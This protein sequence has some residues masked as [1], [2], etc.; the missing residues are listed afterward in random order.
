VSSAA[1]L[2]IG[3]VTFLFTDIEGSTQLL[4]RL[5]GERYGQ[6]LAD[7]Q[8]LLRESFAEHGGHEID[9]QGDSFF[10]A[11]RRAK[12]A[13]SAAIACQR[14]LAEHAWPD[15]AEL[16]VRMGIHTGEPAVGGTRYVGLGVHRAARICAA[17]HGGQ[18][19]VSQTARE[20][21][22]DDPISDVTARDLGEHHLKDLDEPE[23]LYQLV[24][25]GL[26]EDFPPLKTAASAPFEGREGELAEAAAEE[27]ARG[28]GRPTRR[29]L[30]LATF[31][32]AVVAAA[33]AVLVSR[34]GGTTAGASI[35]PNAV[36]VIDAESGEVA[37]EI[38]VG[39]APVDVA[40][41]PDAVWVTNANDNTVS[42]IDPSTNDVRQTIRVGGGPASVAVGGGAVWVANGLDGTVS[43]I[44]PTTNQ[45]VQ[46]ITVGNGPSGVAFGEGAVWVTNSADGTVS[47][48]APGSGRVTR[49][50]PA[51]VGASGVAIGFRRLWIVSPASASVVV[52]DPRSGR[53]L[54]RVGVGA[55]PN[56]VA[57]GAGAVWVANR[58]DGTVSKIDPKTAAVKDTIAVGPK[59]DGVA[60]GADGVWITNGGD[61][62]LF[63]LDPSNGDV[64]K[65][66]QLDNPPRGIALGPRGVYVAVQSR[67][68]EHRGGTLRALTAF[69]PDSIDPA[70]AG[71][72]NAAV[73][74][75]T[76]DGLVGFRKI[77]G[78][79][80]I[81]LVPD[82]AV[83][84]PAPTDGGK[85]YTFQVRTGIQYSNGKRLQP[86]DFKHAIERQF[87]IGV[88]DSKAYYGGI[89]GTER[90]RKAKP[91]EL[92]EG[93]VVDR[94]ARTV[95][96]RITAPDA[97]F[98]AKL[99]L[100]FAVAVPSDTLS[101]DLGTRPVPGTGPYRI[102]EFEPKRKR[103]RLVRNRHFREWSTDAQPQGFPD[104]IS[105]A[106]GMDTAARARAVE[107][108]TA[109]VLFGFGPPLSKEQLEAIAV[110]SPGQLRVNTALATF[111]FFL[112]TRVSP[113]DDVHVRRA[114]N[115]AFDREEF[116]R[117]LGRGVAP[118]CQI[119]PPNLPG[120]HP[121]CERL[122]VGL[123]TLESARRI[124]K[125]RGAAGH[126]VTVWAPVPIAHEGRFMVSTLQSLG[127]RARLKTV[128][129]PDAYFATVSDS[130]RRAQAGWGGWA[131]DVPSAAG[132]IPGLLSCSAF[133]P[134]SPGQSNLAQFCDRSIDSKIDEA[135]SAQ[136]EDPAAATTLWQEVE[137][138]LLAQAPVVPAYN[139]GNVDIVSK[140]VGNYQYNPQWGVLLDQ[141]WVK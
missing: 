10:V 11:F 100:P 78:V 17:G 28:W 46:T 65:T 77:G 41:S 103:L 82:L 130:R 139:R 97:D 120:Y 44:D 37:S 25:P 129:N 85:T 105:I 8:Q 33:L 131:S 12:D 5:G 16:W 14:R 50:L 58:A 101:R 66:V 117:L 87:E 42:R 59:P 45:V 127:F 99:A 72:S 107:R 86:D 71:F 64:V 80:G 20:L 57:A 96:F 67:A 115:S 51:A 122:S 110:R 132:F 75:V 114:V 92:D 69:G 39:G 56:A 35:A 52:L 90:C 125:N 133:A 106:W 40:A 19:L 48:L 3:T 135:I 123:A 4:K 116:A 94:A 118:T 104:S 102:A 73:Q 24:A 108:G 55:E 9:T 49:T 21:L 53:V 88:P 23:R 34:G 128:A 113:F 31:A 32:A 84:I 62:T 36:G 136:V 137:R 121:S 126:P 112:N 60:A 68:L 70:V 89:V 1:E 61:G 79:E 30:I 29:T 138:R 2:P 54:Q 83:A 15:D 111:Y 27:M 74:I 119:L 47:K 63:R 13:V 6:A 38:R 7:H 140:R 76:H 98:L 109:D 18:V 22:R 141:L 81:Q 43:R 95:T 134:A 124:I 93:I 91:C 26:K